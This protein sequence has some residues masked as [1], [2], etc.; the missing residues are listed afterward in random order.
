MM[1]VDRKK[2]QQPTSLNEIHL[3]SETLSEHSVSAMCLK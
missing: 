2:A 3:T 1:N